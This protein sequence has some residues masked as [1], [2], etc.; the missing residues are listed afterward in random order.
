ELTSAGITTVLDSLAIGY[1]FDT[2]QRPRDPR[3]LVD[4]LRAARDAG[5]LRGDHFL[6]LRCE[7]STAQVVED[8]TPL[9]SD[10]RVRLVS[11]MDHT[12]GQRQ[13]V[14][15][16]RYRHYYQGKYGLN[17]AQ[18][19]ELIAQRLDAQQRFGERHRAAIV[20]LCH[21]H[22]HALASHD[23]ATRAHVEEAAD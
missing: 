3:P 21:K 2:G 17:D 16:A 20:A 4:A 22:G 12:P 23:D 9:A 15:V 18:I 5:A 6:H 14:D 1:V 13:Y 19:D 8:F 10:D 11:L 7:V